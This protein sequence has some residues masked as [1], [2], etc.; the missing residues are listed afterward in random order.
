[1]H[2]E[3][4]R[5]WLRQLTSSQSSFEK[6]GCE[7][8]VESLEGRMLLSSVVDAPNVMVNPIRTPIAGSITISG[9]SVDDVEI[10]RN[11]LSLRNEDTQQYWNGSRWTDQWAQIEPAGSEEWSY[12]LDL[13]AGNYRAVARTWDDAGNRDVMG[14]VFSVAEDQAPDVSSDPIGNP[15]EGTIVFSGTAVDDVDVDR[16]RLSL[17][18]ED[19]QQFWNGTE[20]TNQPV[21]FEPEGIENWVYTVDLEAGNYRLIARAWDSSNNRDVSNRPFSVREDLAPEAHINPIGELNPG[22]V[23]LSGTSTDDVEVD[24]NRLSIHNLDT[25][26]YWNG[27]H[28]TDQWAIFEPGGTEEEWSY[29]VDLEVGNYR[30]AVRA[31]DSAG[32]R[33]VASRAFS[34]TD[35]APEVSIDPIIDPTAGTVTFSGT[36]TD[37]IEVDRNGLSLYNEDTRQFWNGSEWTDQWATFEPDGTEDWSYTVDLDDGNY[38]L[39]ARTWDDAGNRDVTSQTFS[40][41][42]PDD[43]SN[44]V[45]AQLNEVLPNDWTVESRIRNNNIW[46]QT[47][48]S[49]GRAQ[50]DVRFGSAGVIAEIRDADTGQSLLAPS[51]KGEQT[52]R[53]IQWTLWETGNT[54]RHDVGSLPDFED[55]FNTTQAGT[56]DNEFN[57]TVDVDLNIEEGQIDVWS[58]ADHNWKSEQDPYMDGTVTSLTRTEVLDGGAILV[59]RVVRIG[60]INLNGQAVSLDRPYFEAWNPLSDSAFDSLALSID[61]NGNPNHWFADG[62]N[63]PYY[64]NTAVA[65]TRGWATSYDR[66]NIR[67]GTNL[68]I[69]FGTDK[70]TLHLA[71]GSERPNNNYNLNLFDFSGGTAILPGLYT[72]SLSE[73][74]IIDQHMILLPGEGIDSTT[75]A[76]LDALSQRLPPPQVYQAG[77]QLEGELFAIADRLA[78]L[79]D[80]PRIETDNIAR[81]L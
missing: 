61:A 69:V 1:M 72:G 34:V 81:V 68:S 53:V 80:E 67:N 33:D 4:T 76:Q 39:V 27:S 65:N 38:R 23:T 74:A 10:D 71:N 25:D 54:V 50:F 8:E 31:W 78:N 48:D 22:R 60:E 49:N 62:V 9:T 5:M 15:F 79:P 63:I 2:I 59:R 42:D 19:T 24:R 17:G 37:D 40:V 21:L 64:P 77:A 12:T 35:E 28:W 29:A 16:I 14:R 46:F 6:T 70:G 57:G 66:D 20:W 7:L 43:F 55:R 36:S 13:E 51:F 26:Q 18:N 75:A 56:F 73:G 44:E 11:R 32:N 58:V 47:V 30:V 3:K 52:D 45:V 41:V